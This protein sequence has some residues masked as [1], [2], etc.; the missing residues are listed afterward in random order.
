M[1]KLVAFFALLGLTLAGFGAVAAPETPKLRVGVIPIA[2]FTPIHAANKLGY[3]KEEGL[4]VNL[5][6]SSGGAQSLPL[7]VQGTLQLSN[8]PIV[9]VAL[10][11]Q[12]GFNLRLIPPA[13]D[14]KDARPGQTAQMVKKDG[15][16]KTVADLK[17]KRIAVNTINSVNWMYDRAFLRQ[18][19]LDPAGVTYV[20]M[21]FPSMIDTLMRGDVDAVNVPQPFHHIAMASGNARVLGYPFVEVQPGLHITA[22]A[23]SAA[24][25]DANPNTVQGFVRAMRRAVE[26]MQAN[27]KEA[28]DLTAEYTKSKPELVEQ[29]PI[30]NWSTTL[31]VDNVSATLKVMEQEGLLKKPLDAKALIYDLK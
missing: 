23:G 24:W 12:Q 15:P 21:P 17:G 26:Y 25:L 4:E 10:A 29:V 8:A 9:S 1:S 18:Y 19:G 7:V 28:K 3:F 30:D 11:N 16:V 31:S 14:E 2:G 27:P 6:F 5:E 20:E 13:L 22:Y